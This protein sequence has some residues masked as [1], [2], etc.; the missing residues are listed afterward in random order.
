MSRNFAPEHEGFRQQVATWLDDQLSGPFAPLR[1]LNNHVDAIP[2]RRAW[3][4]ALGKARYGCIGWP[5]AWGGRDASIAEQVIFAEEY[6]RAKAP[7]R[8]GHIGIELAGPTILLHGTEKQKKQFL[9]GIAS[10]AD[11]W[12]QGYSEPNAGSDLSNVRTTAWLKNGRW[13]IN[14]QKVWTS[15]AQFSDWVF[16]ICR[17]DSGTRGAS[18]LAYLLVPM[19][20]P[21]VTIRPIRQMTGEAEFNEVFFD[22]AETAAEN[23]VGQPGEGWKVAMATLAFE[24]GVSTLGQQMH[25][26]NDLDE[27][28]AL[29]KAN[30]AARSPLIRQRLAKAHVGLTV[31]RA[32]ALRM[33]ANKD[34]QTP[35]SGAYTYKLYWANWRR[36]LGE[37]AMDVQ[38]L[39]GQ[40]GEG[41]ADFSA[42]TKMHLMSRAET[43]Y[44]GT[45][46]IQRNIIA[47]RSLG[48][49]REARGA[50]RG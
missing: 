36:S 12:C 40:V 26:R 49:P 9:P 41:E 29:A 30:G 46:Q 3:E 43:I 14:G 33:L 20:Q 27:L 48:L 44:A 35:T 18:G 16:V 47:E 1:G 2:E 28:V 25:F 21:G 42:L 7:S 31:M 4:A 37:L 8:I 6:A 39:P 17:A 5:E 32:S 34:P 50:E 15:M 19:D 22:N 38:G 45:N 24:R 11:I 10:G 23:I 13:I